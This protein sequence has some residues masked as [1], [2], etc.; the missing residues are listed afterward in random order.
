MNRRSIARKQSLILKQ[1]YECSEESDFTYGLSSLK[2]FASYSEDDVVG[3]LGSV[4]LLLR[5]FLSEVDLE[6]PHPD[7]PQMM[8]SALAS[9]FG[10]QCADAMKLA[11][12]GA[13]NN[14][15]EPFLQAIRQI[16][17]GS[18]HVSFIQRQVDA[19]S[20]NL[21]RVRFVSG[22]SRRDAIRSVKM[23]QVVSLSELYR[24]GH[25][26][27][28][29]H[30]SEFDEY[31]WGHRSCEE[32]IQEGYKVV[33]HLRSMNLPAMTKEVESSI[34][35]MEIDAG[36]KQ[37]YGFNRITVVSAAII[38]AKLHGYEFAEDFLG[39]GKGD[40][41]YNIR[42]PT[43]HF[44]GYDFGFEDSNSVLEYWPKSYPFGALKGIANRRLSELVDFLEE[45]PPLSGK[46]LFDHYRVVLPG[47]NHRHCPERIT[48]GMDLFEAKQTVG[49][50]LG[51]RDG[52][53]YFIGYWM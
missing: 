28:G 11:T 45:F 16:V 42:V 3:V 24:Q 29:Q 36:E 40:H 39:Y 33:E 13:A 6:S 52:E 47:F 32:A 51:E 26:L 19:P 12:W 38:L 30:P 8:N 2:E 5:R 50:L 18:K 41:R 14:V 7:L 21:L 1:I 43:S 53:H 35:A 22:R 20:R 10:K 15:S 44:E 23:M 27:W 34:A 17:L 25:D 48:L 37:Y 31:A 49:V 46:P 4:G 9:D